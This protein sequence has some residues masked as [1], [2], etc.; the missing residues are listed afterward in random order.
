[1]AG[2]VHLVR[3]AEGLH[4]LRNDPDIRDAPL[5]ERGFDFAEDLGRRFIKDHSNIVGAI[6]SS[7]LLRTI[8]TSLTAFARILN[9]AHYPLNSG[10]GIRD[11]VKLT[12]DANLQEIA[13]MP[14]NTGSPLEDLEN[15]FPE[16]RPQI[17]KLDG[18]WYVKVGPNSPLPAVAQRKIQILEK[19]QQTLIALSSDQRGKDVVVVTHQGV[20]AL[21]APSANVPVAQWQSFD[22]AR[23][24]AGQLSLQ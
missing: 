14:S 5:S 21:L 18:D 2:K 11:G 6:I 1:M 15:E 8:Q 13:E 17:Q 23:N 9:S 7:P 16:L 12:L 3:H 4:N 24:E 22:L 10:K 19:L 20:I